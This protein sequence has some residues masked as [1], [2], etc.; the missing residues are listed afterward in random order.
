MNVWQCIATVMPMF[1]IKVRPWLVMFV[2]SVIALTVCVVVIGSLLILG[3][4][5]GVLW[6]GAIR[7]FAKTS[8]A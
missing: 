2:V 8:A 3:V 5:A 1:S 6:A 7:W 4:K